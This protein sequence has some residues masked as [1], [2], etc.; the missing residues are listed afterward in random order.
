[1]TLL[2]KSDKKYNIFSDVLQETN[3]CFKTNASPI[4]IDIDI[5]MCYKDILHRLTPK[6]ETII[7]L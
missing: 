1:M 2:I 3:C 4:K 7:H 6:S 5:Y